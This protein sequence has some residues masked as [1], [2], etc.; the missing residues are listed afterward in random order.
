MN[1]SSLEM[2]AVDLPD[3]VTLVGELQR[4]TYQPGD[5]FVFMSPLRLSG[6]Q[7]SFIKAMFSQVLPGCRVMVL[8]SGSRLGLLSK[9]E[10]HGAH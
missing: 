2:N 5:T 9:D 8:D 7:C 10:T 6:D 3:G 1:N 4:V